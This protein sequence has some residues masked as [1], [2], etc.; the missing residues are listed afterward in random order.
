MEQRFLAL[1]EFRRNAR[2]GRD[3]GAPVA[4]LGA[5]MRAVD[6]KTRRATFIFSDAGVDRMGDIIRA[7]GWRLA[8][9]RRNPVALWAHDD[10]SLPIGRTVDVGV[11]QDRLVG[12]IEFAARDVSDFADRAFRM[13]C[14]G[15]LSTVSVGFAPIRFA[16]SESPTRRYGIDFLEQELLEISLVA[17]PANSRALIV[18]AALQDADQQAKAA[19]RRRQL[20]LMRLQH[21][22]E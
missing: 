21:G 19:R 5:G 9:Y 15:I 17:V 7:A 4:M 1:D 3:A 2:L 12:V 6:Q 20:Q 13:V 16:L 22:P 8:A 11:Q 14:A 18:G 10:K